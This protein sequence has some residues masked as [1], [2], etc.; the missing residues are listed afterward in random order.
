MRGIG[1]ALSPLLAPGPL[2][3]LLSLARYLFGHEPTNDLRR[4]SG[5]AKR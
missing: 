1:S 3:D 2:G 5:T 4:D